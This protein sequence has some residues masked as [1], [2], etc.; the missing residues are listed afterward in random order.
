[1]MPWT[2]TTTPR[3]LD[4]VMF[5][6]L[7]T[8]LLQLSLGSAEAGDDPKIN[9]VFDHPLWC[10]RRYLSVSTS[11]PIAEYYRNNDIEAEK[12]RQ[13][14]KFLN[15]LLGIMDRRRDD[16]TSELGCN[17]HGQSDWVQSLTEAAKKRQ[18][19]AAKNEIDK[20]CPSSVEFSQGE[21]QDH[22]KLM[23]SQDVKEMLEKAVLSMKSAVLASPAS[24]LKEKMVNWTDTVYPLAA[25]D[26]RHISQQCQLQTV[27]AFRK[28]GRLFLR[29]AVTNRPVDDHV[30]DYDRQYIQEW[31]KDDFR[32]S[33]RMTHPER[34]PVNS[35]LDRG[36]RLE[37]TSTLLEKGHGRAALDSHGIML[38]DDNPAIVKALRQNS[39]AID[40]AEDGIAPSN[41]AI[42][43][44][45]L[46]GTL[47]PV[48]F[49][50]ELCTSAMVVYIILTDVFSTVPLL[51]KGVELIGAFNLER[52]ETVA[53][54][55][56]N[57][58]F[59][60][61]EVW[62][63]SCKGEPKFHA[64]GVLFVV[65]A[66]I[67]TLIGMFLEVFAGIVMLRKRRRE[68]WDVGGPFGK[69]AFDT[70][71][72]S[73]LGSGT[74]GDLLDRRYSIDDDSSRVQSNPEIGRPYTK[75]TTK[76]NRWCIWGSKSA[77]KIVSPMTLMVDDRMA[78]NG[79]CY[80][81]EEKQ[82]TVSCEGENMLMG[83]YKKLYELIG[84]V[85][86]DEIRD[87]PAGVGNDGIS[88]AE[89]VAKKSG[90]DGYD[91]ELDVENAR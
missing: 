17:L 85:K 27:S 42:L 69:V 32:D 31:V 57:K 81:I 1:M 90:S 58:Q 15:R 44:L 77:P 74:G 13:V 67:S 72:L 26:L 34:I 59:G 39:V 76:E 83:G 9:S 86:G 47:I 29:V 16:P 70:T 61:I 48:A 22:G 30:L 87:F 60:E 64:I 62:S 56:G 10:P 80:S 14:F 51:T 84:R 4:S 11:A 46:A 52:R 37:R 6:V 36:G 3:C 40:L 88:S 24:P 2:S 19:R 45:P 33:L 35:I 41:I 49:L 43:A 20:S 89:R 65:I 68:G 91:D 18:F 7:I 82:A 79:A 50:A 71:K 63:A 21:T 25:W 12:M 5:F 28:E 53:Y 66:V 75:P 73:L 8:G 54:Y 23:S 38:L 55:V 78:R